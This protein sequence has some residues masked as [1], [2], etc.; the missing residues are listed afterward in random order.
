MVVNPGIMIA[1]GRS[2]KNASGDIWCNQKAGKQER[3]ENFVSSGIRKTSG[4]STPGRAHYKSVNRGLQRL[5]VG[6]KATDRRMGGGC[7]RV[8]KQRTGVQNLGEVGLGPRGKGV[9]VNCCMAHDMPNNVFGQL[10]RKAGKIEKARGR[11]F[12]A[13]E[14]RSLRGARDRGEAKK[15]QNV[16]Q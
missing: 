8:K 4:G 6:G 12:M 9:A 3:K 5:D 14:G 13:N 11:E 7:G 10:W 2:T 16:V 1:A 15:R